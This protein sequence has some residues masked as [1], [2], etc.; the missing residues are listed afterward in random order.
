MSN[1]QTIGDTIKLISN[2]SP[3]DIEANEIDFLNSLAQPTA[4]F[5]TGVNANQCRALVTLLHGN[6]PSGFKAIHRWLR[7]EQA[8]AV[9]MLFIIASTKA[10][11][12]EPLF[13]H[14]MLPGHQ[15]LNRCF[16]M[17]QAGEQQADT[18]VRLAQAILRMLE[19]YQP[20]SVVDLHNTSGSNPSFGVVCYDD[21]AHDALITLFTH[22][23]IITDLRLGA[24]FEITESHF[25]TVTIEVGG[26]KD[27]ISHDIAYEGLC[28][29]A[30]IEDVMG[31]PR[32][33]L[34][35]IYQP[36]IR[37]EL[38]KDVRL[39]YGTRQ[40]SQYDLTLDANIEALNFECAKPGK[41]VGWLNP[42]FVETGQPLFKSLKTS[43]GSQVEIF[44]IR[45][46]QLLISKPCKLFMITNNAEIALSDCLCYAV[47]A[48]DIG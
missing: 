47:L 8:P 25:P 10:A 28:R 48:Q 16:R 33:G 34:I 38:S 31:R 14:R 1:Q 22:R 45:K 44:E 12:T 29:Y 15:D 46:G 7:S 5:Q 37:V 43:A 19:T 41:V 39:G 30:L 40:D 42:D 26:R 4:F 36:P 13:S 21:K 6:E 18:E 24:L 3:S 20:E 11:Q 35:D 9:N 2:P 27:E 17:A 32:D 23:L